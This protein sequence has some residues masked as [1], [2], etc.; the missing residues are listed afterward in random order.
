MV[1]MSERNRLWLALERLGLWESY[2]QHEASTSGDPEA[3]FGLRWDPVVD[4]LK[5]PE[6]Q[7]VYILFFKNQRSRVGR[8]DNMLR[9]LI[10]HYRAP[11]MSLLAFSWFGLAHPVE[12]QLMLSR[13]ESLDFEQLWSYRF[14]GAAAA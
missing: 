14:P 6:E 1:Q 3:V 10:Q 9:T 7:G 13:L 4:L 12:C 2:H 8:T 11:G 5:V